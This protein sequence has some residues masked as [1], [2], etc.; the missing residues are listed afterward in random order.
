M[1]TLVIKNLVWLLI[2]DKIDFRTKAITKNKEC[3]FILTKGSSHQEEITFQNI[4][5]SNKRASIHMKEK[6]I[7]LKGKTDKFMILFRGFNI[8]FSSFREV[9]NQ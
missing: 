3:Y 2:S 9:E 7:E 6:L 8:L 5:A 1:V 4:Y